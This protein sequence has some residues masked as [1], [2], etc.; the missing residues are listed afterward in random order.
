MLYS[1]G[2]RVHS[3][4]GALLEMPLRFFSTLLIILPTPPA[5][6]CR[7]TQ[8][9]DLLEETNLSCFIWR[10]NWEVR[11][12]KILSSHLKISYSLW[13]QWSRGEEHIQVSFILMHEDA[14][15][16]LKYKNYK[17]HKKNQR[18][19]KRMRRMGEAEYRG[20]A[21]VYT[22]IWASHSGLWGR[23]DRW[24]SGGRARDSWGKQWP[25]HECLVPCCQL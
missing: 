3:R 7:F 17:W 5:A 4:R 10:K 8:T 16:Y 23:R 24:S 14:Y 12:F 15:L 1:P 20:D 18:W 22:H 6:F 21:R 9:L 19:S 25:V 2:S 11:A 13:Y